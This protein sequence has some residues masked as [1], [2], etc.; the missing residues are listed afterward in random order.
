MMRFQFLLLLLIASA[1]CASSSSEEENKFSKI[2]D[3]SQEDGFQ[4]DET[5]QIPKLEDVDDEEDDFQGSVSDW[6]IKLKSVQDVPGLTDKMLTEAIDEAKRE[7]EE[8]EKRT[9]R[10]KSVALQSHYKRFVP[11]LEPARIG[12]MVMERTVKR[13]ATKLRLS[14]R[15][16]AQALVGLQSDHLQQLYDDKEENDYV[17]NQRHFN[18]Y[19]TITGKYNNLY[20]VKWGSARTPFRRL[21]RPAYGNCISTPRLARGSGKLP[22]ARKVSLIVFKNRNINSVKMSHMAMIWGQFLDHDITIGA[23]PDVDCTGTCGLS[24]ECFGIPVPVGDK[25]FRSKGKTCI[26]LKRDVPVVVR[27]STLSYREQVN[28]KSAYIDASQIYGDDP[29]VFRDLRRSGTPFLRDRKHPKGR[30]FKNLLPKQIGGFCRTSNVKTMPCF[31]AGDERTNENPGLGSMHT[32]W[33]REHNRIATE[34]KK[35]NSHWTADTVFYETRKIVGAMVQHITYNELL[36]LILNRRTRNAFDLV[37]KTKAFYYGYNPIIDATISNSFAAAAYRFGHSLVQNKLNRFGRNYRKINPSISMNRFL[38]PT[39]LYQTNK[40][41]I[42]SI[43]RG[44]AKDRSQKVDRFFAKAVQEQLVRGPGDLADLAALNIQRA[45]ERGIP[46]YNEYRK[47]AGLKKITSF[48]QRRTSIPL[49]RLRILKKVYKHPDD[50]DLFVGGLYEKPLRGAVL[51]RVFSFILADQFQR[52]RRGDRFWYENP[53]V[54]TARQ[55]KEIRK[56]RLSNVICRNSDGIRRIQRWALRRQ[57]KPV[58]CSTLLRYSMN[59]NK[60]RSLPIYS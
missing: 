26:E 37:R 45:R 50:I 54:F 56:V 51:G 55:L 19:R 27:R 3:I 12:A 33:L 60:W 57:K 16:A 7:T 40:G 21:I 42:D 41:G 49:V 39:F 10:Q 28:L 43:L 48:Q 46:G 31:K 22:N 4:D 47:W 34:L 15:E 23:Q 11:D 59:L 30:S 13:L 35:K 8:D 6:K 17:H 2:E 20:H 32:I 24:G 52:L 25:P 14:E 18:T 9:P 36:P 29:T 38:D 5:D 58:A 44:L 1:F 53:G